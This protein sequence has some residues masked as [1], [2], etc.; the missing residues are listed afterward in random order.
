MN[1]IETKA[2]TGLLKKVSRSFYL[3]LRVLP[4]PVRR[5]MGLAYLLARTSDTIADTAILP[6]SERIG[7]LDAYL[8]RISGRR[9]N[10]VPLNEL[11]QGQADPAER[12]LLEQ[13]E[14]PLKLLEA[15]DS[16]DRALIRGVLETIIGGQKL[17]LERFD[18]PPGNG[19]IALQH[20]DDLDDYTFRVAGCVGRFWTE[21][22][23]RHLLTNRRMD[24]DRLIEDGIRFGKGLQLINILRDLPADLRNR[25]CYL[26]SD[27]LAEANLEPADL[28]DPAC[29]PRLRPAYDRLLD[30][31][32][33]HLEHGWRYTLSL[34][35]THPRL[36]LACAW[37]IL[38]GVETLRKLRRENVL[39]PSQRVKISRRD[40][41]VI[42]LR[43]MLLYPLPFFW[44]GLYSRRPE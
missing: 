37:P 33:D 4:R 2:L 38:I 39:D 35:W 24:F 25:R 32:A 42:L 9:M 3:T 6:A 7:A 34:P 31:A 14:Q 40:V 8:A 21:I 13:N 18:L 27:L 26:P 28:L 20:G 12:T 44:S 29:E 23:R 16:E 41:K 36:R 17:D 15:L 1:A 19:I 22:C 11:I 43:S 5:Q 30:Q 10:P